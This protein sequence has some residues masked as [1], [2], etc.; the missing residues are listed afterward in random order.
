MKIAYI[1]QSIDMNFAESF[2]VQLHIYHQVH[3][4]QQAGHYVNLLALQG[5]RVLC[6]ENLQ[7]FETNQLPESDYAKLGLSG[8]KLFKLFESVIRRVQKELKIPYL[9][10]FDSFRTYDACCKTLQDYDVIHERYN[11][12]A[13]GG[14]WASRKLGIPYILEVNSDLLEERQAQGKEERG[15]RRLFGVWSTRFCFNRAQRIICVSAQLKDHLAQK[16]QVDP[17]KLV[18]LPNAADTEAFSRQYDNKSTRCRLGLNDE[19]VVMF[20][21]GFYLWHDLGLLVKSFAQVVSKIPEAKLVLVGDGRTRSMI[22]A[23]VEEY[24]LQSAVIMAGAVEHR[25]VPKMLAIAAVAVAPN[26][27]FFGGHGGSPLK[28]FEYMAAGKAIVATR[29]GQVAEVIQDGHNGLLV[30]AGDEHEWAETL[31]SL[32]SNPEARNQ[33]GQQARQ[34]AVAQHSWVNYVKRLEEIYSER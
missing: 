25:D 30:E 28:I 27:Q 3:G 4:L 23:L 1:F 29:T 14:A 33:L 5:R 22:E 6:T 10:L 21:G 32:L 20:V 7:V 12:F 18:V 34:Q 31:I 9:A 26:I 15:L 8:T 24:S 2:A 13:I 16:W 11:L 19:P 17:N